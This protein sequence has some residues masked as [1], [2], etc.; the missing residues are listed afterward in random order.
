VA[1]RSEVV[2][3]AALR[4]T[5]SRAGSCA[6]SPVPRHHLGDPHL[7]TRTGTDFGDACAHLATAHNA[8]TSN[9]TRAL[10]LVFPSYGKIFAW[11][12]EDLT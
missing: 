3:N 1:S 11:F 6:R 2:S 12:E 9:V 7:Q 4:W 10:G 5:A 8:D